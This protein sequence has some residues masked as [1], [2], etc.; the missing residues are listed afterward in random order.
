MFLYLADEHK[1]S[2]NRFWPG[3]EGAS[4]GLEVPSARSGCAL[5]KAV[6]IELFCCTRHQE[7]QDGG[8]ALAQTTL[9]L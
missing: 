1:G 9:V 4:S 6:L 5:G 7:A 3:S 2:R 8:L